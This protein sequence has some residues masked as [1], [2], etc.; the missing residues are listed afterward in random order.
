MAAWF[1]LGGKK[2]C[3][4][5]LAGPRHDDEKDTAEADNDYFVCTSGAHPLPKNAQK[6]APVD[7]GWVE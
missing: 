7:P 6:V 2:D 5:F 4:L 1:G 3:V